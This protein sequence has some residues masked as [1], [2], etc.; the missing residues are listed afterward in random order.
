MSKKK[1][2]TPAVATEPSFFKRAAAFFKS[3][4]THFAAGLTFVMIGIYFFLSFL[5]FFFTGEA[6]QSRLENLSFGELSSIK[7]EITNWTGAIGA[8]L[9][10]LLINDWMGV[11]A[12]AISFFLIAIGLRMMRVVQISFWRSLFYTFAVLIWGSI[13]FGFFFVSGY[14]DSF[15]YL[16]GL[17]GYYI[18]LLLEANIGW[19]GTFGLILLT[20]LLFMI[21]VNRNTVRFLR[22]LFTSV[23]KKVKEITV[24]EKT[25]SE[26]ETIPA[27]TSERKTEPI[28]IP[29]IT[30]S[31]TPE[32]ENEE[33]KPVAETGKTT[34]YT[35]IYTDEEETPEPTDGFTV[36][37]ARQDD[38][39]TPEQPEEETRFEITNAENETDLVDEPLEDYDPTLDLSRYKF[40]TFDLLSQKGGNDRPIDMEEQTENKNRITE[41][42]ENYGIKI[43]SIAATVGPTVT[44][45]EIIPEAGVRISKIKNLE[46]DIAL[47]LAALGIRIIAPIPGKGTIGIEVP[48]KDPQVVSGYSIIA[49][50]AFQ[51]CKYELPIALGKTITND[52]FMVDLCKMPHVLVAG[53]TGQGKSVGLNAIITSLLYK[54]HPAQLK[55][56]LIDPKKVEFN[57]YA[58]LERHYIAK[59]PDEE[60]AIVTDVTKVVHTLNSLTR[61]MDTRYDL[62]KKAHTR[63]IKEYNAK[64][65]SRRL[66]PNDGH[67]FM[68]YIVVIIDE[69]ADL[70]ATAGKEVEL[71]IARIAQL[72]RAVG[73]HMIIATQRPSTN[74]ITGVIKANFPARFAFRVS[75]MI[76]SRTILDCP[77]ANQLIG[78]GDMLIS[79]NGGD[80][81]R[82]QCAF[83]DTPEVEGICNFIGEQPG[84]PHAF[85]LPEYVGESA[86]TGIDEVNLKERDP[87]FEEA[88]RLIVANQQGSTSLI[89]RKFSIGYNR[90]GRIMDQLEAAG[91]VGPFE[92]SKARQVLVID[93][94]HLETIFNSLR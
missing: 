25:V 66:N 92:G 62:M 39:V 94:I 27:E 43:K 36:K 29:V 73:I 33:T 87:M 79:A 76:D 82:V 11:S 80:L 2:D 7:N 54:K 59:L 49:S 19:F 83:I 21:L 68:P 32:P 67:H 40:P 12:F 84:Y 72:A 9:S 55:F 47:S 69:F 70:I 91:I 81:T 58:C 85:L 44:L 41:T 63:Q 15:I 52:V 3:E 64:F 23:P 42:L 8:Y 26:D 71:P 1:T 45:Y 56:V 6:D 31:V 93:D 89:Q 22:S 14:D 86:E 60:D 51:E 65:I 75:S 10:N 13:F 77:G 34:Y 5:S 61:E 30:D 35:P 50:R 37:S 18:T 17:H 78:R 74:V 4:I 57:I 16:G 38:L 20:F 48:N 53:A 28:A 88:A 90:A 46:D 24:T